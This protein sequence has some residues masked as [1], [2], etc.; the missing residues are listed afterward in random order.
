MKF[1]KSILFALSCMV[2]L[3]SC[4]E[5]LDNA[6]VTGH[7]NETRGE[8]V[9]ISAGVGAETKVSLDG[10][11][12]RWND[13]GEEFTAIFSSASTTF[14]QKDA[15]DAN[16]RAKF[17]GIIPE[18]TSPASTMYAVY[19]KL[20]QNAAAS[21]I[22]LD[23]GVQ[24]GTQ[25]DAAKALLYAKG[26]VQDAVDNNIVFHH[27]ASVMEITMNF[28]DI[29]AT[30][31]HNETVTAVSMTSDMLSTKATVDLT[32]SAPAFTL[33]QDAGQRTINL[34]GSFPLSGGQ[35]KIYVY[36]FPGTSSNITVSAYVGDKRYEGTISGRASKPVEAGK[37]YRLT[38]DCTEAAGQQTDFY[39]TTTGSASRNGASWSTPTTLT[40]A[41]AKAPAG[42]TIHIAAGTYTPT[43]NLPYSTV[44][45]GNAAK[46]FLITRNITLQGGY[47][48]SP[49]FGCA[50]DGSATILSGNDAS[51][52]TVFI[53]APRE[54]GKQV[55]LNNL[56]ISG[57]NC[58][59]SEDN[60][61]KYEMVNT[62]GT[63]HNV[64]INGNMGGGIAAMSSRIAMNNV[65]LTGNKGH[66]ATALFSLNND[67][68]MNNCLV[69]GN[70]SVR[71][72]AAM[73]QANA[74]YNVTA[75]IYGGQVRDNKSTSFDNTD[76]Y[77]KSD[78]TT[79]QTDV[80][81]YPAGLFAK[82]NG[83][84]MNFHVEQVWF[85][86]NYGKD[87]SSLRMSHVNANIVNCEFTKNTSNN[88]SNVYID[89]VAAKGASKVIFNSCHFGQNTSGFAN[90]AAI[91]AYD[92][93]KDSGGIK[94][95]V[96][97]SCIVDNNAA[98][99]ISYIR[100]SNATTPI[101]ATFVNTTISGN[102]SAFG[103]GLAM[104]TGANCSAK[105]DIISCTVA[106]NNFTHTSGKR[107]TFCLETS[108]ITLSTYNSI[109]TGNKQNGVLTAQDT[110][111]YVS[112]DATLKIYHYGS[113]TGTYIYGAKYYNQKSKNYG[114]GNAF[115]PSSLL[116]G[117]KQD[118][119][120]NY[121][122][123]LL[124]NASINSAFTHGNTGLAALADD[125]VT[126]AVLNSDQNG[127][128][129]PSGFM[130]ACV[131]P[132]TATPNYIAHLYFCGENWVNLVDATKAN[133][134]SFGTALWSWNAKEHGAQIGNKGEQHLIR[135]DECKPA[136]LG[137]QLLV[138]SSKD[139][140]VVIDVASKDIKFS[141]KDC[142]NAHSAEL[143]PG[144]NANDP[145][146]G[147][148]VV[149]CSG[150]Y[151]ATGAKNYGR[152]LLYRMSQGV[153]TNGSLKAVGHVQMDGA[154]GVIWSPKYQR[155]YAID[156]DS[157]HIYTLDSST[158][159]LTL[160]QH[161][162]HTCRMGMHDLN[163]IDE[164][165]LLITGAGTYVFNMATRTVT[166]SAYFPGAEYNLMKSGN[167]NGYDGRM[168]YTY[169]RYDENGK[170]I[171]GSSYIRGFARTFGEYDFIAKGTAN[172]G[173]TASDG[174]AVD[175]ATGELL[176]KV[177][178]L[179][180]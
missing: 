146:Q 142:H 4:M 24:S 21:A 72:G 121:T 81:I 57:G 126:T 28:K 74:N 167:Y 34:T 172:T 14:R 91:Y 168:W 112:N 8:E 153:D 2:A 84:T 50:P 15:P 54:D 86:G 110:Q 147:L 40:S 130:G 175:L 87:G 124:G 159:A 152:L 45:S 52:H 44:P 155:L 73:F 131:T 161:V 26:T 94:L 148:L 49:A 97:N 135:I 143:I 158:P 120:G 171:W 11:A 144:P 113:F 111:K 16:G 9:T 20:N 22:G 35:S 108:N 33:S 60:M 105:A 30:N 27:L 38:A 75:Y 62:N 173:G 39:V 149:A 93:C 58:V 132:S 174:S 162:Q 127:T 43:E 85:T 99:R 170:E 123:K 165:N 117:L 137:S 65:T 92:N 160:E 116:E 140:C 17:N 83:G 31:I 13:S 125:V 179:N 95:Y 115:H 25:M 133:T 67:I 70:E 59:G 79:P 154:H 12:V 98:D 82:G 129:R 150:N 119:T 163:V 164:D 89:H 36:L 103:T 41:L 178:V 63:K 23:L 88:G 78:G 29:D 136:C 32:G 18:G 102:K 80:K 109:I 47:P 69:K 176:Y 3:P 177:K 71:H 1:T 77:F 64:S 76:S 10:N 104:N 122:M 106:N 6:P 166:E 169:G 139:Y 51:Y 46:G 96:I 157:V 19:P 100:N 128:A 156:Y 114:W 107:G 5:E 151:D 56:T 55:A 66:R 118:G 53:A 141:A 61:L 68:T 42:S 7:E 90:G 180:W 48:A 145:A 138:T 37:I 101:E 134:T